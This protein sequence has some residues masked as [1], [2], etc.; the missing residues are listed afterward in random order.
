MT[1]PSRA[2]SAD[3]RRSLALGFA[4]LVVPLVLLWAAPARGAIVTWGSTATRS[5]LYQGMKRLNPKLLHT[6]GFRRMFETTLPD[7]G[8]IFAQPLVANGRLIVETE[9]NFVYELD[10]RTGRILAS[11]QLAPP[12]PPMFPA[13]GG[14]TNTCPDVAPVIGATA[15]PVIDTSPPGGGVVYLTAKTGIPGLPT[16]PTVQQGVY[17]VYALRLKD[18]SNAPNW[19]GGQ[20][21]VLS[22]FA[23]DNAP[24]VTFNAT[25]Q[26]QR[27]GL[28]MMGGVIYM[29]FGSHCD[30]SP[31]RGWVVGVRAS[32]GAVLGRWVTPTG[33]IARGGG[34]WGAGAGL[35]SDGPGR[36]FLST[37]NG[38]TANGLPGNDHTPAT[39][40][41]GHSPPGGLASSVVRLQVQPNGT[42]AAADFF[43]PCDNSRLDG[44][45]DKD[46]DVSSGGVVALP[47]QFGSRSHRS[48][49]LAGGKSGTVY[50]LDRNNLGGHQAGHPTAACPPGG[51]A[52]V[53]ALV[54][55]GS[56]YGAPA[57]WPGNG[58]WFI[59]PT[60]GKSGTNEGSTGPLNFYTGAAGSFRLAG[61]TRSI[62]GFGSSSPV[63]TSIGSRKG[64]AIVWAVDKES[65]GKATLRAYAVPI[66]RGAHAP[67][68]LASFPVGTYAKFTAPGVGTD[69]IYVGN[70]VGQVLGFGPRSR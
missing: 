44:S 56:I 4:A 3:R 26:L 43:S 70:G 58:G 60:S 64:S 39:P 8:K 61:A 66:P 37:G 48:V 10:P 24:A 54:P 34:T 68:A 28:L 52:I 57:V 7:R 29:G 11:R 17:L 45:G 41:P 30:F 35:M 22:G 63:I 27:P 6:G 5:G 50:V 53:Q 55:H 16:S 38:F 23:A 42:L 31:F 69:A 20:P 51:D 9:R 67:T 46:V 32:D 2:L 49:L 25:Y 18:L 47:S 62:W 65:S 13:P 12:W 1:R 19:G 15:T 33:A 40:I 36:I 21:V 14:V 59:V